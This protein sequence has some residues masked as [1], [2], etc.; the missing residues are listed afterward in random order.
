MH[1]VVHELS[2]LADRPSVRAHPRPRIGTQIE[3]PERAGREVR[4]DGGEDLL[5]SGMVRDAGESSAPRIDARQLPPA[6]PHR[7][8][9]DSELDREDP[10]IH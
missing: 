7:P 5:A 10:V 4:H 6:A 8:L 2:V 3:S 1:W 9:L